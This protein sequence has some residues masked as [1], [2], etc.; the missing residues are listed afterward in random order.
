MS[1]SMM[2]IFPDTPHSLA[3]LFDL[4][5]PVR[6]G[7]ISILYIHSFEEKNGKHLVSTCS[8]I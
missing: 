7:H 3:M 5:E 8:E 4:G 6:L 1:E 2:P